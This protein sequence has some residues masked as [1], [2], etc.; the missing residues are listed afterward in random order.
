MDKIIFV[1]HTEYIKHDGA[2]HYV[3]RETPDGDNILNAHYS[4]S[5]DWAKLDFVNRLTPE[6]TEKYKE[7]KFEL[8]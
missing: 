4:S 5:Y 3:F 1:L 2:G 8:I 6:Q 7:Y